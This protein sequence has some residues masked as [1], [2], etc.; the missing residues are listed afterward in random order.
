MSLVPRNSRCPCGSGIKYKRCCLDRE[1]ELVRRVDALEELVGL[2]SMFPL[3]RPD[4]PELD[5]WLDVRQD[6]DVT[7]ALIEEAGALV[8]EAE[9][10]R[11]ARTHAEEFPGVWRSLVDDLGDEAEAEQAVVIGAIVAVLGETRTVDQMILELIEAD[12]EVAADPAEALAL[13]LE[14]TDLWS[15]A[16]AT[17]LDDA[18]TE[19]PDFLDDNAYELLWTAAIRSEAARLWSP[20]HERRLIRLVERLRAELPIA[21][22][23]NA[24]AVLAKAC[25]VFERDEVVRMKVAALLLADSLGPLQQAE[26]LGALAA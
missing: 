21:G 17:A 23:P 25:S 12:K 19:I 24:S 6:S 10:Q 20:R 3:L 1:R 9:R 13:A 18:L 26:T 4:C 8:P 7:R 2:G 11:I 14:A 22:S 5:A 15:I 16:E